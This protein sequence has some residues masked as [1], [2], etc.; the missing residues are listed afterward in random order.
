MDVVVK[1]DFRII[2]EDG[3]PL[4]IWP[5]DIRESS[6]VVV[7]LDRVTP[8]PLCGKYYWLDFRNG[9][10]GNWIHHKWTVHPTFGRAPL[11]QKGLSLNVGS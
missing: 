3:T 4:D 8:C 2:R 10:W 1:G 5:L 6:L 9:E 7:S 11:D